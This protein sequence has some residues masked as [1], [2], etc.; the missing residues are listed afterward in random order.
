MKRVLL[1]ASGTLFGRG[2]E[3]LLRQQPGLEVW[4]CEA[5]MSRATE[6]VKALQ[7]DVVIIE[8][9]KPATDLAHALRCML[10]ACEQFKVIELDPEDDTIWIHSS[11][12]QVFKQVQDLVEA[13]EQ[14]AA[15]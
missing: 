8:R 9:R 1:V 7:P 11:R 4:V 10:P 3:N 2:V 5:D 12:Q 14:T 15:H 13:I 6:R